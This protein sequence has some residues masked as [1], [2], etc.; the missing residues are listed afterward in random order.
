MR[1]INFCQCVLR[2]FYI[3]LFRLSY[4]SAFCICHCDRYKAAAVAFQ[5]RKSLPDNLPHS[6]AT[7]LQNTI[8]D[9]TYPENFGIVHQTEGVDLLPTYIELSAFEIG[10]FNIKVVIIITKHEKYWLEK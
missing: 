2:E 9:T 6:L 8:D 7:V 3:N 5:C 4:K 10:L 1:Q